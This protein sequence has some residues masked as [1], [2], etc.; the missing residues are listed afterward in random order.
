M[1]VKYVW[2]I[3]KALLGLAFV[4]VW[5]FFIGSAPGC[6]HGSIHLAPSITKHRMPRDASSY[7]QLVGH[8]TGNRGDR[9][10]TKCKLF[11]QG[12]RRW[13]SDSYIQL[14]CREPVS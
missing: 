10:S 12:Q 5:H 9:H 1:K 2:L 14:G 8:G 7:Q 3:R 4:F 11:R 6:D 13:S